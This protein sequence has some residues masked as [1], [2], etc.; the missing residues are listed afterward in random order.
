MD[1]Q[2]CDSYVLLKKTKKTWFGLKKSLFIKLFM[3]VENSVYGVPAV[4]AVPVA[5]NWLRRQRVKCYAC[6]CKLH[7]HLI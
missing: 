1:C 5:G 6:G 3:H 4:P 7:L 2:T